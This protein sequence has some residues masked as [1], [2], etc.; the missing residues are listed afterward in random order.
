MA[1]RAAEFDVTIVEQ[2][3]PASGA[4]GSVFGWLTGVVRDDAADVFL[5]RAAL[6]DWHRLEKII[7]ELQINCKRPVSDVCRRT[8]NP[9]MIE[10]T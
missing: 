4:T 1:Y 5:R 6:A 10:S 7:P 2:H 9:A 3:T 8:F